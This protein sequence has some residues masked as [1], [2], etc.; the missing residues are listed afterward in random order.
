MP[1]LTAVILA[2]G[3][4]T[5]MKSELPKVLHRL[6]GDT[7]IDHV[8]AKVEKLGIK[9]VLTIVGHGREA[10]AKHIKGRSEIVVQE[11]Q[12]GTGHALLQAAPY[13]SDDC[14]VLVL[15]GDQPLLTVDT[16]QA[17]LDLQI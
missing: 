6:A 13:L 4:G 14:S 2:A 11:P 15:S 17:M 9:Q 16:L 7:L 1:Q 12:L 8:L 5:R 3:K 10:V